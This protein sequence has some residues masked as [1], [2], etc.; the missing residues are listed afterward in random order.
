MQHHPK[1]APLLAGQLQTA[2]SGQV[3]RL[4]LGHGGGDTLGRQ[5]ILQQGQG[6]RLVAGP[7]L[8]QPRRRKPQPQEARCK[9]IGAP[10]HPDH[11]TALSICQPTD[12]LRDKGGRRGPGFILQPRASHLMPATQ[13]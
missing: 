8:D 2:P 9:E 6:F 3:G 11:H 5:R 7:D 13:R 10:R 4:G 1:A 12:Q